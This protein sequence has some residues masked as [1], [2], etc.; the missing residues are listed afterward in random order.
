MGGLAHYRF[1]PSRLRD[2][3]PGGRLGTAQSE[4]PQKRSAGALVVV[5]TGAAKM[6]CSASVERASAIVSLWASLMTG[7]VRPC[8]ASSIT[9]C[10][11]GAARQLLRGLVPQQ[12]GKVHLLDANLAQHAVPVQRLQVQPGHLR[13]AL[14][15]SC[16]AL[17]LARRRGLGGRGG[18]HGRRVPHVRALSYSHVS[19]SRGARAGAP[20]QHARLNRRPGGETL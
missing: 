12:G 17:L 8:D 10:R 7:R 19:S 2:T 1:S 20:T 3:P 15:R 11:T 14:R 5:R 18:R 9:W 4:A 13:V 6:L 16:H